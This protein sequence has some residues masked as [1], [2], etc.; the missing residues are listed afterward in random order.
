MRF[1]TE[2]ESKPAER[3]LDPADSVVLIGSC[4]T[5][6]IGKRMR[7]C[8]WRAFPNICGTLYNP[9]SIANILDIALSKET[10]FDSIKSSIVQRDSKWMS[11]LM[12]SSSITY[13]P[14]DTEEIVSK[15]VNMLNEHLK[16][17]G[18]LIVTFGTAWIYELKER[19]GYVVSNCHKF[20]AECFLRRRLT[21]SEIVQDWNRV[22]SILGERYPNLRVIFTVSPI[23]HLKDGFE[24]NS[25]SKAILQIACEELCQEHD[26]AEY[27]PSF[28]IMNDDLR[29][30]RYY[31]SDMVHP[32]E[33]AIEYIWEKFQDRYLSQ[34]SRALLREGEK[35]TRRLR[36]RP[37][38]HGNSE[39]AK[40]G[41]D[42]EK[43][44]AI[45]YYNE[46]IAAH[47]SMLAIDE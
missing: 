46:F 8:R 47:P 44:K 6:N 21:V 10:S 12:D 42:C 33:L 7:D 19:P 43:Y 29:D 20:P 9:K 38:L 1:R 14:Y 31:A 24:G 40:Y 34:E 13:S 37:I 28:E 3:L 41:A 18:T 16:E 15:S 2:Y 17:A 26:K 27:F 39:L 5:D 11:W 25:C 45:E 22:L 32:S 23:R 35:V 4:F 36:H 30:Y